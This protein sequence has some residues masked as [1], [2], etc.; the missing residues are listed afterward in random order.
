MSLT[1]P[2]GAVASPRD[3]WRLLHS[4]RALSGPLLIDA[5]RSGPTTG[6]RIRTAPSSSCVDMSV[7]GTE[8]TAEFETEL[9]STCE[10][11]DGGACGCDAFQVFAQLRRL[12]YVVGCGGVRWTESTQKRR[13]K[14]Q[15]VPAHGEAG[16]R[17]EVQAHE[18]H[19]GAPVGGRPEVEEGA[20]EKAGA[21][22][23]G[24]LGAVEGVQEA[25]AQMERRP[26]A[27]EE[28]EEKAG[29]QWDSGGVGMIGGATEERQG[30]PS[31]CTQ[32]EQ[33]CTVLSLGE[34]ETGGDAEGRQRGAEG[35]VSRIPQA[36]AQGGSAGAV[37]KQGSDCPP[38]APPAFSSFDVY[39]PN[40]HFKKAS[41]PAPPFSLHLCSRYTQ[42]STVLHRALQCT[43]VFSSTSE[44]VQH[45]IAPKCV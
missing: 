13:E 10:A 14:R 7:A 23:G 15:G 26:E 44:K 1:L 31:H 29:V 21:T 4:P 37:L 9:A 3:L 18:K 43:T 30:E 20:Q 32:R 28:V 19:A 45:A 2:S 27:E 25:G 17:A 38:P 6:I 11:Y 42:H 5:H 12:G 34:P 33:Y 35:G 36:Y 24:R 22:I 41:P 16:E 40:A 8:A 39:L